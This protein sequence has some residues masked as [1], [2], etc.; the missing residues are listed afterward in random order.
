MK[1]LQDENVLALPACMFHGDFKL[2][3]IFVPRGT[4]SANIRDPL[5]PGSRRIFTGLK[6]CPRGVEDTEPN[7][8]GRFNSFREYST[9]I[10]LVG[11]TIPNFSIAT[12]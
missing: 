4:L 12:V 2:L 8:T 7:T 3:H 9:K 5:D 6:F 10:F 11:V 1:L